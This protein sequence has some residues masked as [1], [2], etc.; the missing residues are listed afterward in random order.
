MIDSYNLVHAYAAHAKANGGVIRENCQAVDGAFQE[1]GASEDES[2]RHWR[3]NVQDADGRR[4]CICARSD[5]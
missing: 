1:D 2:K 5:I 4:D 3:V